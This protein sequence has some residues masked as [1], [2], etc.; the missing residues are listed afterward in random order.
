MAKSKQRKG[1]RPVGLADIGFA[2]AA[3]GI[4]AWGLSSFRPR[5]P[6]AGPA[7][8]PAASAPAPDAASSEDRRRSLAEMERLKAA[9]LAYRRDKGELPPLG[10]YCAVCRG[11]QGGK[12]QTDWERLIPSDPRARMDELEAA[13]L[14]SDGMPWFG[15]YLDG[16]LAPD[17]WGREYTYDDNDPVGANGGDTFLV[18][19]GPD[20]AYGTEDDVRLLVLSQKDGL[21]PL[22]E[23]TRRLGR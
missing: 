11:Y 18:S 10:D 22:A 17:P 23:W 14:R 7:A 4:V 21:L 8:P 2:L 19:A 6:K 12:L 1:R 5:A 15:P 20:R 16:P 13:L 3:A 9:M